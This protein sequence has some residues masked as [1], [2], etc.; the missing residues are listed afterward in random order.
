MTAA[1]SRRTV[2]IIGAGRLGGAFGR[3]L[4]LAGYRIVAVT[5][6]TQALGG[7]GGAV[8]RRRRADD[9]RRRGGRGRG[10]RADHHAGPGDPRG[11][12]AHRARRRPARAARWSSTPRARRPG[13]CSTPRGRRGPCARCST[14]CSRSRAG[15]RGSRT[16]PGVFSG[17]RPTAGRCRRVRALVRALGG[18]ELALPRWRADPQS[19]ALYHAGAVAA[20]NYLVTLLDFAARHLQALG[21]DRRQALQA[22]LPLVRGTLANVER[23]GIPAALTG[24]I[25][26]GDAPTVA[27][28]VAALRQRAPELLELYRLLARQTIPLA[29]EQGGSRR[30]AAEQI[31]ANRAPAA[32]MSRADRPPSQIPPREHQP[33]ERHAGQPRDEQDGEVGPRAAGPSA[34]PSPGRSGR[35]RATRSHP[36]ASRRARGSRAG[37]GR[38]SPPRR[39]CRRCCAGAR[40]R[41]RPAPSRRRR[42]AGPRGSRPGRRSG[43]RRGAGPRAARASAGRRRSRRSSRAGRAPGAAAAAARSGA[44]IA[45]R[46]TGRTRTAS[47][48]RVS[49]SAAG[50]G[51]G[52]DH[53]RAERR[54]DHRVKVAEADDA[55]RR[56]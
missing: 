17:S 47:R 33:G 31:A 43:G 35:A 16:S 5:A 15:S 11:L 37:R 19:A 18:R 39:P 7:G 9:G 49:T 41:R 28:H 48:K 10:D 36:P 24:P 20:S 56:T 51:R 38:A 23:L 14:R 53:Q 13:S 21:A 2:A 30:Q 42:P 25:A 4:A 40:P 26:R 54:D 34:A 3:L 46:G 50:L 8:H 29:R 12:R 32:G 44:T 27:G 45:R 1:A 52:G 22:L 55:R 6:R